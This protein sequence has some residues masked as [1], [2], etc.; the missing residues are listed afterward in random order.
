MLKRLII[1]I[2]IDILAIAL[3]D[4]WANSIHI[5]QEEAIGVIFIV[6]AIIII[7]GIVGLFLQFRNNIWGQT[8]L[9]N[10]F[11][12]FAIFIGVLKY[13]GWKQRHDNYLT[14]YFSVNDKIYNV[15][16]KLNKAQLQNGLTY[17]IYERL[18][19]YGN[20]GTDLDGS[21]TT[22]ND[23][24]ILKSNKGKVMKIFERTLFD[25][26]QKGDLVALRKNPN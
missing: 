5:E 16:L 6:P 13:E 19:E 23:T 14:F 25:Y 17:D 21:Y 4:Y 20:A 24:L 26:P 10:M 18:G 15:T 3:W 7:S 12:A 22:K 11:T 8:L 9:I 1:T 2:C